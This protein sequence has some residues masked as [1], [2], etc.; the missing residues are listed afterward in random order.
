VNRAFQALWLYR[1]D[2][3]RKPPFSYRAE[4]KG[5]GRFASVEPATGRWKLVDNANRPCREGSIT[6]VLPATQEQID[7][8]GEDTLHAATELGWELREAA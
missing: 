8:L 3:G 5:F 2:A 6:T 1:T 4:F 7:Q